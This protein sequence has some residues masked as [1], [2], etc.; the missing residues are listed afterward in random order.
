MTE[1]QKLKE[2]GE[3]LEAARKRIIES[4][5]RYHAARAVMEKA[6]SEVL[7]SKNILSEQIAKT[8]ELTKNCSLEEIA[9]LIEEDIRP[10]IFPVR[11]KGDHRIVLIESPHASGYAFLMYATG[12]GDGSPDKLSLNMEGI[13]SRR[14]QVCCA[15]CKIHLKGML[16]WDGATIV[17]LPQGVSPEDWKKQQ[18]REFRSQVKAVCREKNIHTVFIR[19]AGDWKGQYG[20]IMGISFVEAYFCRET[21][22]E[23][24]TEEAIE[25]ALSFIYW[26][27]SKLVNY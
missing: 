15:C 18:A 23:D 14:F 22:K 17:K 1:E 8:Q 9:G 26:D 19:N 11:E 2:Q 16:D 21:M 6:E 3:L 5:K 27:S 10:N 24:Y 25:K 20:D 13:P 7:A 12:R 4:R